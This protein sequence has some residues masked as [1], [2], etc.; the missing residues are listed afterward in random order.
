MPIFNKIT[1]AMSLE[2]APDQI[3]L[4]FTAPLPNIQEILCQSIQCANNYDGSGIKYHKSLITEDSW[5]KIYNECWEPFCALSRC[6][7]EGK[8]Y[9]KLIAKLVSQKITNGFTFMELEPGCM[10]FDL[11]IITR[12]A[13]NN[14][15][16]THFTIIHHCPSRDYVAIIDET[17]NRLG[18]NKFEWHEID[19]GCKRTQWGAVETLRRDLLIQYAK[20]CGINLNIIVTNSLREFLNAQCPTI[21]L[22]LGLDYYDECVEVICVFI[23]NC[24]VIASKQQYLDIISCRTD[25]P[26]IDYTNLKLNKKESDEFLPKM[27]ELINQIKAEHGNFNKVD[28]LIEE[29]LIL[30]KNLICDKTSNFM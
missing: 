12:L 16:V 8:K 30:A 4:N 18:T 6:Y 14:K 20:Y 17:I 29:A 15:N 1:S 13:K 25:G 24:A 27:D 26:N 5:W 7:P 22:Y 2:G 9:R 11:D 21:D 23:I 10:L 19:N 3:V 28:E